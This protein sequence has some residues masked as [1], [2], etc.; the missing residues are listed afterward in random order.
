[1]REV[2]DHVDDEKGVAPTEAPLLA[3]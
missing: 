1:V 2:V 3:R